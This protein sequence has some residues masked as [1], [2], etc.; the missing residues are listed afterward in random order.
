MKFMH[1]LVLGLAATAMLNQAPVAADF[2][3][4]VLMGYAGAAMQE[5]IG[6]H[7]PE[8]IRNDFCSAQ[9]TLGVFPPPTNQCSTQEYKIYEPLPEPTFFSKLFSL[10]IVSLGFFSVI[11]TCLFGTDEDRETLIGIFVGSF[12]HAMLSDDDD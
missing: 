9:G 7:L 10:F 11:H 8:R 6:S 3:D 12:I 2:T 4:G 5:Q 1:M